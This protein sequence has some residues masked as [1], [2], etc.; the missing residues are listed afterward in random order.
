M[1]PPPSSHGPNHRR[2]FVPQITARVTVANACAGPAGR[3]STV[4]APPART[5][6]CPR[7]GRSAAGEGTASVAS[8]FAR[9]PEP[10]DRPVNVALPV[11]IPVTLNGNVSTSLLLLLV[12]LFSEH[13]PQN[14]NPPGPCDH[15]PGTSVSHLPLSLS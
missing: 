4:T 10:L 3:A 12:G 14:T 9:I 2:A 6:A 11:V 15:Q 13:P 5:P 1:L 7:T 8:V